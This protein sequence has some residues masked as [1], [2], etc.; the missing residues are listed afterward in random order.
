[1]AADEFQ[2]GRMPQLQKLQQ[3]GCHQ[4]ERGNDPG[5]GVREQEKESTPEYLIEYTAEGIVD[6]ICGWACVELAIETNRHDDQ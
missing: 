5:F 2:K 4:H 1:V 3:T 6:P